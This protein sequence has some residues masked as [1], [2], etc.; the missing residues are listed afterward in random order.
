MFSD[1]PFW[2][3]LVFIV[4]GLL[5][6]VWS[7]DVFIEG[8]ASVARSLGISPLIIGMVIIGFGTSAPE[9]CVSV[10][11]GLSH[12]SG[13]S[14]GNAYGSCIFNIAVILG[15]A[16]LIFPMR[17]RPASSLLAGLILTAFTIL[18]FVLLSD[19]MCSRMDAGLLLVLFAITMPFYCWYDNKT[20]ANNDSLEKN[21]VPERIRLDKRYI[22]ITRLRFYISIFKL[23]IGLVVLIGSSHILV[24]GAVD[25]AKFLGV[26]DL[27]IGLTI[28]SIGTSLPELASAVQSARKGEHDFVMGNIIGSNIFNMLAVVGLAVFITPTAD[29]SKNILTRDLPILAFLSISILLFGLNWRKIRENGII[30]RANGVVWILIYVAYLILMF[31]EEVH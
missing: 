12:H 14:L 17:T 6:L 4:G 15:A 29:Y 18:S 23:V 24:V 9:L 21:L 10:M 26:S 30:S 11:S 22:K 1:I 25:L 7:S 19:G 28:V 3:S 20:N 31:F 2:L 27:L 8:S 16:A 13:I 5:A